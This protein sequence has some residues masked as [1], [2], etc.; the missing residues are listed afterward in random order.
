MNDFKKIWGHIGVGLFWILWPVWVVYFRIYNKRSRI[1]V[2]YQDQILLVQGWLGT[3]KYGLPGGGLRKNES[4]EAGVVRELFEETSVVVPESALVKIGT[5][6]NKKYHFNY[7]ATYFCVDL[8]EDPNM[9]F[10][11]GE[12]FKAAWLPLDSLDM[13]LLDDEAIYA[14]KRY[15]PMRQSSLL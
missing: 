12:I 3:R 11:L 14:L 6:R 2:V 5:R 7:D 15:K 13:S 9:H 8:N 4:Y 1:V 10:K